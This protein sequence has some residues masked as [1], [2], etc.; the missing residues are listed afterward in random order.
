MGPQ[1][2]FMSLV[3]TWTNILVG[4]GIQTAA[5]AVFIPLLFVGATMQAKPL[6]WL[7]VI[8]TGLSQ[9]RSYGLRR[10]FEFVRTRRTPPDFQHII[11]EIAAE[12]WRQITGEGFSLSHDDEH[13]D[14]E[15]AKAAAAY[16]L[17]ASFSPSKRRAIFDRNNDGE[18]RALGSELSRDEARQIRATV[19]QEIWPAT[20]SD[21]WLKPSTK[22]RD[23]IKSA[24]MSIA[25]IGRLDRLE[26]RTAR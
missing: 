17:I 14:G 13:V 26:R 3:E 15:L 25:E 16:A 22:R 9:I 19:I 2:R 8:M 20:W 10:I 12:R 11:E 4:I 23:L 5:N 7:V 6:F 21:S 18:G 1:S 24:A